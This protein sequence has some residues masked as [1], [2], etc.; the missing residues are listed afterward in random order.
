MKL[1]ISLIMVGL[2]FLSCSRN[3]M[4]I[5]GKIINCSSEKIFFD[6]I[7]IYLT[8]AIDSAKLGKNGNF[9]FHDNARFPKFYQLRTKQGRTI[10]L[11]MEPGERAEI[12][13]DC[14]DLPNSLKIKGS[15]GSILINEIVNTLT[16]TKNKL[17]SISNIYENSAEL[18][19]RDKLVKEYEQII[20]NHR[21]Y[22][23]GFILKHSGSLASFVALY[24]QYNQDFFVL[25]KLKD[26][27]FYKIVTDS[28][29]KK[30][31]RVKQVIAL[32]KNTQQ[33]L[34]QYYNQKLLSFADE[35]NIGLPEV[36]LPDS[37]GDTI[38]LRSLK[39]EYI[40]LSFWATWNNASIGYN[41]GL[42]DV[43]KKYRD[44]GFEIYHIS[45]DKSIETWNRSII[46]DELEWINVIDT[47]FPYSKAAGVYNVQILP[48]NYLIDKDF[49]TILAKNLFPA[50]L[51]TRLHE[52]FN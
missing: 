6:E 37:R 22:T 26:L 40:L 23:I 13:A 10:Q 1:V 11:L 28:L 47:T 9:R 27:Q 45:L 16:K 36:A 32:K 8:K 35:S 39:G 3:D 20:D 48:A 25:N 49:S 5:K 42:K 46:F 34:S 33:L 17:D 18:A 21:K 51:D 31:P 19:L 15:E 50:Q 12:I 30:Y 4:R 2:F 38:S 24:Q 29:V 43:Y 44:K 52:L 14:N 7:D 41:L